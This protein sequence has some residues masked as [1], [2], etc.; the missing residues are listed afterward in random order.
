MDC[1]DDAL[2][3]EGF[4]PAECSRV[5]MLGVLEQPTNTNREKITRTLNRPDC[6]ITA[7]TLEIAS[8]PGLVGDCFAVG[9]QFT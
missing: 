8:E 2:I 6:D 4:M 1:A 5:C 7:L 9:E 3:C